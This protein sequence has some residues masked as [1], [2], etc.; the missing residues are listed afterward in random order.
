MRCSHKTTQF[1]TKSP[2][3]IVPVYPDIIPHQSIIIQSFKS[4]QRY[5]L[6]LCESIYAVCTLDER[7]SI[8]THSV[9]VIQSFV[10]SSIWLFYLIPLHLIFRI[11]IY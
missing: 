2:D 10:L 4:V 1:L 7:H 6:F 8:K 3:P 9:H 5:L 11:L